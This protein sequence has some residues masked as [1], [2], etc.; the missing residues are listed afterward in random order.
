MGR[1]TWRY[2]QHER[3]RAK[4]KRGNPIWRGVGCV[5]IVLTALGGYFFS[6][7]FLQ[8]NA[9]EGW[10]HIPVSLLTP[11]A[12]PWLPPGLLVQ[13]GV[14]ILFMLATAGIVDI[15]YAVAFPIRP[16]ETDVP[17]LKRTKRKRR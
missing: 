10:V 3:E 5:M 7:W 12:L 6:G 4:R 2:A 16:G 1:D 15:L 9:I 8:R 11:P 17:P 13:L 14:A